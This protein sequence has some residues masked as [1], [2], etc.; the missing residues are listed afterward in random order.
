M[1][2]R[3]TA[4]A[5]GFV[6]TAVLGGALTWVQVDI[7]P[8]GAGYAAKVLCSAVYNSGRTPESVQAE[9][10]S[11]LWYVQSELH[12]EQ[13]RAS[14]SL[15]GL[16]RSVAVYREGL[17]CTL[18]RGIDPDALQA[19]QLSVPPAPPAPPV[20]WPL[21]D[22]PGPLPDGYDQAALDAVLAKHLEEPD[23]ENPRRTRALVVVHGGRLVAEAYAEGWDASQ[24]QTGWSMSKSVTSTMVALALERGTLALDGPPPVPEWSDQDPRHQITLAQMLQMSDGLAF[25][26]EYGAFGEATDMLY[27]QPD[28]AAFTASRGLLHEPGTVWYYSSGTTNLISRA[29]REALGDTAYHTA[30]R[31]WLFGPLGM[32][33]AIWEPDTSGTFVG[34][35]YVWATPRDWAKLGQLML[36][37][38]VWNGKRLLPRGWVA[39]ATTPAPAADGGYGFQWWLNA[40]GERHPDL[41][42]DTFD[43]SGYEG[44]KVLVVPSRSLVV[45]RLG[46]TRDR[47]TWVMQDF[48]KDVLAVLPETVPT[49]VTV[50][51]QVDPD[52]DLRPPPL[53]PG[54]EPLPPPTP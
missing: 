18:A 7:A 43:A 49:K 19:Q 47:S 17:G 12:P 9:E 51:T 8:R 13:K 27:K 4:W 40:S 16:G 44:Q 11:W 31:Q 6:A 14:A 34:S 39:A 10:L 24:R 21:G 50:Q 20:P 28:M 36:Q 25:R 2:V 1:A 22:A 29:L 45:V 26:E 46:Q 37:D 48:V 30:P 5:A 35:S 53:P 33:S 23:P 42:T 41:P 3:S 38:G 15:Y 52:V 32:S 54:A